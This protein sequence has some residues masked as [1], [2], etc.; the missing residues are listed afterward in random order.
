M[1][2]VK[3]PGGSGSVLVMGTQSDADRTQAVINA[4]HAFTQEYCQEQGWPSNPDQLSIE[5]ILQI[6]KQDGWKNP[7]LDGN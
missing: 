4:R 2:V 3:L 6:R 5:Q 7:K 1:P